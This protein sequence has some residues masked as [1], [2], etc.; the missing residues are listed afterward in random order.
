[1]NLILGCVSPDHICSNTIGKIKLRGP[2]G[3]QH[4]IQYSSIYFL[5][6]LLPELNIF[7][8]I[9]N[10]FYRVQIQIAQKLKLSQALCFLVWDVQ[11]LSALVFFLIETIALTKS[12]FSTRKFWLCQN[13]LNKLNILEKDQCNA[14]H[15]VYLSNTEIILQQLE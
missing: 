8:N 1:M 2:N 3:E 11:E 7:I 6:A 13:T 4:I 10:T 15:L 14:S 5:Q 9:R 12:N